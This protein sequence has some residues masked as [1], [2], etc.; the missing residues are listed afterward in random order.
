MGYCNSSAQ[1]GRRRSSGAFF[2]A[3]H[4]EYTGCGVFFAFVLARR[5]AAISRKMQAKSLKVSAI[6]GTQRGFFKILDRNGLSGA[7]Q[8]APCRITRSS[9]NVT[10]SL[11]SF[12]PECIVRGAVDVDSSM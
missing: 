9:G 2:V 11:E 3:N 7:R 1:L 6:P 10:L 5:W 4:G 12:I 8:V